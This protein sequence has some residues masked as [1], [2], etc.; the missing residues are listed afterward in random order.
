MGTRWQNMAAL[1]GIDL[2][3]E[4]NNLGAPYVPG[5]TSASVRFKVIRSPDR[6]RW[7][8]RTL[9]Q[10]DPVKKDHQ[11]LP[12]RGDE[13]YVSLWES[14]TPAGRHCDSKMRLLHT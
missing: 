12:V 5:T 6:I 2:F 14:S 4:F 3:G 7:K 11:T 1:E 10:V 13:R 9:H 8:R